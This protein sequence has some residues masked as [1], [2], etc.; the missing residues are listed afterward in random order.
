MQRD[1]WCLNHRVWLK[2]VLWRHPKRARRGRQYDGGPRDAN[3]LRDTVRRRLMDAFPSLHAAPLSWCYL[4]A[5]D[6]APLFFDAVWSTCV[7]QRKFRRDIVACMVSSTSQNM[8]RLTG[9]R[10][11]VVVASCGAI[12]GASVSPD[13]ALI[14]RHRIA[15]VGATFVSRQVA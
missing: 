13:L 8:S 2:V 5:P 4:V 10:C 15:Y 6:S 1:I 9:L 14:G 3:T 11:S 7:G 12:S